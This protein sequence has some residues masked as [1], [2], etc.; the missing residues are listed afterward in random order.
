MVV[1]I[2]YHLGNPAAII[3]M[4]K[5]IG[6]EAVLS[7]DIEVV[8]LADKIILPG[9]GA[10]DTGINNLR[11][12]GLINC[13]N[14]KVIIHK[15]PVLGICLGMQLFAKKSEE[16]VEE[17]LNWIDAEIVKFSFDDINERINIPNIGWNYIEIQKDSRLFKDMYENPRF[18][19]VHSY[20]LSSTHPDIVLTKSKYGY[21]Y[22]SGIEKGNI[23][24]VQ[25]HPEKSHKFGMRI[26]SNFVNL[27]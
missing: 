7:N 19:F 15:T 26:L 16:G 1:V 3:N 27:Y 22:I 13:L 8:N 25:F 10:F 14:T 4:L 21:E 9:V 12:L 20:H 11:K 6:T 5:R 23:I 2:D 17:G 24:G 18:Y